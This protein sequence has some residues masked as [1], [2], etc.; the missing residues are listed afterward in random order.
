MQDHQAPSAEWPRIYAL[1]APPPA[2][3]NFNPQ[4]PQPTGE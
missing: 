4:F 1:H 3:L 2:P